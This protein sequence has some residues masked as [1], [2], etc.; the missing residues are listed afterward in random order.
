MLSGKKVIITGSSRGIGKST[1]EKKKKN[2]ADIIACS[3]THSTDLLKYYSQIEIENNIKIYPYFFDFSDEEM[4]RE[5]LKNILSEHKV[6]DIL[7]NNAGEI[8]T[9]IFLMTPVKKIKE[10]FDI[11]YFSLLTFTQVIAKKMMGK[12][13]G[14]I[15]NISTTAAI[16]GIEGRLAYSSSKAALITTTKVLSKELGRFNIRVNAIAPGLTDTDLMR[17]NH[18]P[19][20]IKEVIDSLSL[21]RLADPNEIAN[22][23]L[24][25]ASEQ[26]S[27]I[28]GQVIRVDGGMK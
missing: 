2:R 18:S 10:N 7:V 16:D 26:S 14:N 12:K 5:T 24:F 6:I 28:T 8:Q 11:N 15:I 27:Y 23:V 25:L 21:G 20:V 22:A 9:S 1:L 3:K 17:N 4:V 19:E 13:K